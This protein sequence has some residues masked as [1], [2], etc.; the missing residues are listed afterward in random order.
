MKRTSWCSPN[1]ILRCTV[2]TTA[3]PEVRLYVKLLY[4][5]SLII[6][7]WNMYY[8][9]YFFF[10]FIKHWSIYLRL[11]LTRYIPITYKT[12][13]HKTLLFS[14]EGIIASYCS[15]PLLL[16]ILLPM[17][18]LSSWDKTY[19]PYISI[20]PLTVCFPFR[21]QNKLNDQSNII[22]VILVFSIHNEDKIHRLT[23]W[24]WYK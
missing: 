3:H 1:K 20:Q 15:R 14:Q 9:C 6:R 23:M 2:K 5:H 16:P 17:G 12:H 24:C 22:V 7:I 21:T 18:A 19:W 11:N 4:H 8:T 10:F 13:V